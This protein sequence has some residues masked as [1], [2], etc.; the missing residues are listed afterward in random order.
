MPHTD[1]AEN[2]VETTEIDASAEDTSD[3]ET[4]EVDGE[5]TAETFPREVVEKLRRENARFRERAK[6]ADA[7]ATR[8][9]TELVKATGRLADPT[10]LPFDADHL[11]DA[12]TLAAALDD[13][14]ARKPHLASRRPT[15]DIGQGNRGAA[16]EPFSLLGMLKERA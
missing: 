15:G 11:D 3:D 7:Y 14:L 6:A 1:T 10:D 2:D 16:S 5:D 13:L 9:H 4:T 8:L 12:E